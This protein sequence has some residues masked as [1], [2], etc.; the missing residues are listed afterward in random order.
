MSSRRKNSSSQVTASTV[1]HYQITKFVGRSTDKNKENSQKDSTKS[2]PPLQTQ[3]PSTSTGAKS[4]NNNKRMRLDTTSPELGTQGQPSK[5]HIAEMSSENNNSN[6]ST[7]DNETEG[8]QLNLELMELKRQF[9]RGFDAL[10]DQK[11]EPLKKDIQELKNDRKLELNEL[12]VETLLRRIKQS[13]AKYKKLESQ[14]S[15]I[16]DQLLEQNLIF[17]GLPETEFEDNDNAKIKVIKAMSNTM[18]GEDEEEKKTKAG[19]TSIKSVERLGKYN[20]LRARPVKV[21]FGNKVD[22]DHILKNRKKLPKGIYVDKEYSKAT[23]HDR[24]LLCPII[25]AARR[26]DHYKGVCRLDGPGW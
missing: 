9:F 5:K 11:L 17:Q 24:K 23:E 22:A 19:D 14:I 4:V 16:E 25:K 1:K 21:K 2:A 26:L 8:R 6:N 15:L 13:D 18:N 7:G 10:I 20:L 12:N 3:I